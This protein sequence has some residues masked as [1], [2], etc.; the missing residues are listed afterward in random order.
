[1]S[2]SAAK[3]EGSVRY[4]VVPVVARMPMWAN[5][6]QIFDRTVSEQGTGNR[7]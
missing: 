7:L 6:T 3:R 1:L 4:L 5:N 2:P